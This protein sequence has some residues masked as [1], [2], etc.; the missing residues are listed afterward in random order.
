[1][2]LNVFIYLWS[3]SKTWI[4]ALNQRWSNIEP[5]RPLLDLLNYSLDRL[6]HHFFKH[7]MDLNVFILWQSSSY[8]LF[9][10]LND[11]TSNF[12]YS[13]T[14][15]YKKCHW[16]LDFYFY[17][18]W[19]NGFIQLEPFECSAVVILRAFIFVDSWKK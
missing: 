8:T 2:D 15:R 1:M 17:T 7:Q 19:T 13:S 6:K 16:G 18:L 14:H 4:L 5:K 12:E 3:N 10:A 11:R 9:L